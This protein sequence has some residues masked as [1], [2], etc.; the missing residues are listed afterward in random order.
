MQVTVPLRPRYYMHAQ[1]Q[2]LV[3]LSVSTTNNSTTTT[4]R[5]TTRTHVIML[6]VRDNFDLMH[7]DVNV[8]F[9]NAADFVSRD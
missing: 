9:K 3:V 8:Y 4:G 7:I 5:G 2:V 6:A 1:L